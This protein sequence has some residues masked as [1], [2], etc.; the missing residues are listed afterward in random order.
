MSRPESE[1]VALRPRP[2][3]LPP[4]H[5]LVWAVLALAGLGAVMSLSTTAPLALDA[6]LP[7]HFLRHAL[8]LVLGA[9]CALVASRL[10]LRAWHVLA[11]PLW[12]AAT[13]AL[14]ATLALGVEV[15]G[16]QRWLA[17]PGLGAAFQPA[18]LM[19]LAG[20]IAVAAVVARREGRRPLSGR[21]FG[22]A[23]AL[24]ALPAGLLLLQPDLGNALLLV[25]LVCA[26]LFAAGA[27]LAWLLAP[28]GAVALGVAAYVAS[29]P[30]AWRRWVGFLD[31]WETAQNQG[32]QLVQSFVAFGRGGLGGVGWGYGRQKLHYLPEAHTDF[33]LSVIAEELGLIGVLA[34]LLAFALVLVAGVRIALRAR[35]RFAMLL[36]FGLTLLLVV[37][38]A[39]NAAVV[40]GLL[41]TKGLTLPFL[42]YGRSSLLVCCLAVGGLLSVA[43]EPGH[44]VRPSRGGGGGGAAGGSGR[45]RKR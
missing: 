26:L 28:A 8:A 3:A 43:R 45:G 20:V 4:E 7:P 18:E 10:P 32:F 19:K 17:L 9:G 37:P 41:P 42:S 14:L 31:P 22:A 2:D 11:L 30:Y 29:Q 33:V 39:L 1:E 40:M 23:L 16:A 34:V 21:R 25:G 5:L 15:K 38:A 36:A 24:G 35:R 13:V 6:T 12:A 44:Q 27:R